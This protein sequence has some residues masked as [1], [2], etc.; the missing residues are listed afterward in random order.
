M[1]QVARVIL[2]SQAKIITR[3]LDLSLDVRRH[4]LD[5]LML[6][7]GHIGDVEPPIR[8]VCFFAL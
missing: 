6:R 3:L 7:V 2:D 5:R 1:F 4:I 8:P